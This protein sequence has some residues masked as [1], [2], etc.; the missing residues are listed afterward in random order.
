[1]YTH[2]GYPRGISSKYL[3]CFQNAGCKLGQRCGFGSN[4]EPCLPCNLVAPT[5]RETRGDAKEKVFD[6][7]INAFRVGKDFKKII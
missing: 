5:W 4:Q 3:E 6:L 1:M 7:N 2:A